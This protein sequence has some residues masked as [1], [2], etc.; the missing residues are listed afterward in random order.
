MLLL[1][2]YTWTVYPFVAFIGIVGGL[3]FMLTDVLLQL[4]KG[5]SGIGGSQ[6]SSVTD[7][8]MRLFMWPI[9]QIGY[10]IGTD[11]DGFQVTP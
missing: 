10:I 7:W 1:L 2:L 6:T 3:L 11:K 4:W 9:H 5:D 8:E